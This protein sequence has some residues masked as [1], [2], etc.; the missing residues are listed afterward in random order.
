MELGIF[1]RG[2][3]VRASLDWVTGLFLGTVILFLGT[4]VGLFLGTVSVF[5]E[6]MV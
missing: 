3:R 5:P 4:F 2:A 6:T 1:S